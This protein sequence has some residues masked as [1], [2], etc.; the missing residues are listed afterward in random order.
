[1]KPAVSKSRWLQYTVYSVLRGVDGEGCSKQNE[2]TEGWV[3]VCLTQWAVF[4]ENL[5]VLRLVKSF[6]QL[7]E[8][9]TSFPALQEPTARV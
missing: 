7:M 4:L 2:S 3:S 9:D 5:L 6:P 1:M 8:Q